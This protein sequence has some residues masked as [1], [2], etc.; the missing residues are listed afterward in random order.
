M[1][2][3]PHGVEGGVRIGSSL[4]VS[5]GRHVPECTGIGELKTLIAHLN[6]DAKSN[7]LRSLLHEVHVVQNLMSN[8]VRSLLHEVLCACFTGYLKQGCS[9]SL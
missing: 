1:E 8:H 4:P 9:Q 5:E 7:H 2:Q 6:G 3:A